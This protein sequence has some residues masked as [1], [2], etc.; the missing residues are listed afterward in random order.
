MRGGGGIVRGDG[1]EV[2]IRGGGSKEVGEVGSGGGWK[3]E[4]CGAEGGCRGGGE[5]GTMGVGKVGEVGDAG[6]VEF[7]VW[8]R[9]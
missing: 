8:G 4:V 1:G 9:I 5:V 7:E 3:W 2:G 6:E